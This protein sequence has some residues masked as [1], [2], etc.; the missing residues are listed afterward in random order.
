MRFVFILLSLVPYFTLAQTI[1]CD[2]WDMNSGADLALFES[3]AFSMSMVG[4]DLMTN[5]T[6]VFCPAGIERSS[7]D[8]IKKRWSFDWTVKY[9]NVYLKTNDGI[10]IEGINEHG[11]SASLMFLENSSL[12]GKQKEL[13]PIATSLLVNFFIDHFKA[14]D[15]AL[16][17]VWDIRPYNDVEL[18]CDWPFRLV[19]HDSTGAT[20]YIEYANGQ[21]QVYTP[22]YPSFIVGG[23]DYTRLITIAYLNDSIIEHKAEK[24]YVDIVKTAYPPNIDLVL[25]KYY[26]QNFGEEAY[27]TILRYPQTREINFLLPSGDAANFKFSE[28]EFIPGREV[29]TRYF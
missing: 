19:L 28:I 12:P 9:N 21:R 2:K 6:I 11:F 1:E 16:L 24:L 4:A 22:D 29:S 27:Y 15:T 3:Q 25:L 13:I 18:S 26:I 17:A 8:D 14:I 20:A 5:S 10:V 23:P 7:P